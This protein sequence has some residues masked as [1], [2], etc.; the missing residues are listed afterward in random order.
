MSLCCLAQSDT[1]CR[2]VDGKI[3]VHLKC[4]AAL[5]TTLVLMNY[6]RLLYDPP[7]F[8]TFYEMSV[9]LQVLRSSEPSSRLPAISFMISPS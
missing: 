4:S 5:D 2:T 1:A 9:I 8:K 6:T 3:D 7:R